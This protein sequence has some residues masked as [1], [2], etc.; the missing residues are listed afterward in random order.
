[1]RRITPPLLA[2]FLLLVSTPVRAGD[3][4]ALPWLG[5]E[6]AGISAAR[7][8]SKP[9]L[10]FLHA[11][12]CTWCRKMEQTSFRDSRV[13]AL[14][15][16]FVLVR[17][18]GEKEGKPLI[19]RY[20]VQRYPFQAFVAPDGALIARAPDF[21]DPDRYASLLAAQ[22]PAERIARL[23]ASS[24]PADRALLAVIRAERGDTEGAAR[25]RSALP[26]PSPAV[27][28]A[29]GAALLRGGDAAAAV[30]LLKDAAAA[31]SDPRETVRLRLALADGYARSGRVDEALS[32]LAVLEKVKGVTGDEKKEIKSRRKTL[33][34]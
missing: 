5:S 31:V 10:V 3:D 15:D 13:V 14:A 33:A 28:A 18:N 7:D 12:Y 22:V 6:S 21:M 32:E 25:L 9:M 26:A 30:P 29:L 17:L 19:K 27:D 20:Q 16:A 4:S 8:A 23:E 24:Q 34:R 11:D 2:L 1:M